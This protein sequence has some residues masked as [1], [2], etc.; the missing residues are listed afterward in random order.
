MKFPI[1]KR[2]I[3]FLLFAFVL[4]VLPLCYWGYQNNRAPEYLPDDA[5]QRRYVLNAENWAAGQ[6]KISE[7]MLTDVHSDSC[8]MDRNRDL[9]SAVNTFVAADAV[10]SSDVPAQE[11]AALY[12]DLF[13]SLTQH[14]EGERIR[15]LTVRFTT[16]EGAVLSVLDNTNG[17]LFYWAEPSK[18]FDAGLSED[19][20]QLQSFWYRMVQDSY[21]GSYVNS[22]KSYDFQSHLVRFDLDRNASVLRIAI[23]TQIKGNTEQEPSYQYPE[24]LGDRLLNA[25]LE[26]PDS[27]RIL[28]QIKISKVELTVHLQVESNHNDYFYT[29][30]LS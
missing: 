12:N 9:R 8:L 2:W 19:E 1:F 7:I 13:Q 4:A 22:K 25:F 17:D 27:V 3:S 30:E 28:Q 26:D 16:E 29:K 18:R 5:L 21:A 14:K 6:K 11:Q 24:D 15:M 23:G 10:I 20:T